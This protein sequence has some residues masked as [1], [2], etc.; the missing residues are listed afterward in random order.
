M[1]C[2]GRSATV[3]GGRGRSA[4]V[5]WL[6]RAAAAGWAAVG[7]REQRLAAWLRRGEERGEESGGWLW[8][9]RGEQSDGW[10]WL[11]GGERRAE[12]RL[13]EGVRAPRPALAS[14]QESDLENA[15]GPG[16]VEPLKRPT[17]LSGRLNVV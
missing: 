5:C 11:R 16:R 4:L 17:T 14:A 3:R 13:A 9:R 15:K 8:L 7:A 10:L 6:R 1:V 2:C 12:R